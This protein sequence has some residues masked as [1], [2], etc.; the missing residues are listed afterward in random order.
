MARPVA[1]GDPSAALRLLMTYVL[2]AS[3][4]QP[5]ATIVGMLVVQRS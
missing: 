4:W 3:G 2:G 1:Q 5:Q